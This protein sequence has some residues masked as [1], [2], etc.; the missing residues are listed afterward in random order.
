MMSDKR[1]K[2]VKPAT[3]P[4]YIRVDAR[5]NVAIVVNQGG[6]PAGS[7]FPCGL[8]LA[9]PVPEAH[10]VALADLAVDEPILRYGVVIG[11][12]KQPITRG[13]WVH[14]GLMTSPAAPPLADCPL[15]TCR[16][17]AFAETRWLHL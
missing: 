15:A 17:R 13:S 10:K 11:Y 4:R 1:E 6:L 5:D 7:V 2:S 3:Q 8:V 9:E 14:E 12:A 16:A